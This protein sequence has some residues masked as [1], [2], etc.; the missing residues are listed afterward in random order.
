MAK[1][2]PTSA[3]F[4]ERM[5]KHENKNWFNI[6]FNHKTTATMGLLVPLACKE[7]YPGEK[8]QLA[9][10]IKKRFA[11]LYLP[12]M[13]QCYYTL[14]WYFIGWDQLW[15]KSG[16]GVNE[17]GWQMFIKQDPITGEIQ[18][19]WFQYRR[20]DAIYTDGVLNYLGFNAPP[21]AGTLILQ[22]QV[23]AGPVA[24]Y[25]KVYN[26]YYRNDQIQ[27]DSFNTL[28]S[29]DNS[30]IIQN[31]VPD[32]RCLRRNWPRDYYTSATLT[33]QQGENVLIPSYATDPVTGEFIPQKIFS[34]DGSSPAAALL[35][36]EVI[37]GNTLLTDAS[38]SEQVVLQLSSTVRDFRYAADMT[39]FLERALRSGDRYNDFVQ[40]HFG[41]TPNPLYIDRPVW[42]GG[43]TGQVMIQEVMSTAES[44][45]QRVGDYA[46]QALASDG[47]PKISYQVPDF[48]FIMCMY[49]CYP[50]ASYYSG[51]D[52]MW[53]RVTKMDYMWE[54]FAYI[55]D[56]PI[57]NKEV[58]FSWYTS[59]ADWNDEIF[60]Y[61]PQYAQHR[62][63]NDIVSGQ[64]R[65]LWES[66]HLGRKFTAASQ[67]VL[68]SEFIT[69]TPDVG[70]VFD[71]DAG[72]GEHEIYMHAYLD[73]NVLRALPKNAIPQ[74]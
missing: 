38:T 25:S 14:D 73:I 3:S 67:V 13:H 42:L 18:W 43:Y 71:V 46:G 12:I 31:M 65:T 41:W 7:V 8:V 20:A 56:Q 4:P 40:R 33:P 19:P 22:T 69:C 15:P 45:E 68:N 16:S 54:Q 48:G 5:E 63:S 21:P 55:G 28:S 72:A 23:G 39:E 44:G 2:I 24:A 11:A 10:E 37:S 53:R 70:R 61:L 60:G 51:L 17:I 35:G 27:I 57:R 64:M 59:D 30:I 52:N 50:K 47:T 34:L 36:T 32:L 26:E 29:G 9:V 49:T 74:T 6:G 66:F 58:W 62:Y 1:R